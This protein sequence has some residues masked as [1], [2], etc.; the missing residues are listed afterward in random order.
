MVSR[1]VLATS[2]VRAN[3]FISIKSHVLQIMQSLYYESKDSNIEND[4]LAKSSVD[5]N[6]YVPFQPH[7]VVNET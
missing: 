2:I 4:V 6:K 7:H 1:N 3:L 5:H